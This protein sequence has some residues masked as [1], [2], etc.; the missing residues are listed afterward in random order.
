MVHSPYMHLANTE[1]QHQQHTVIHNRHTQHTVI[2]T[3]IHFLDV[4]LANM[5]RRMASSNMKDASIPAARC[6]Y[7]AA[8]ELIQI[9]P[10]GEAE[11]GSQQHTQ[12]IRAVT[13]F[14]RVMSSWAQME[15][16]LRS[17]S[18]AKLMSLQSQFICHVLHLGHV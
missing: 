17:G 15:F 7:R 10:N 16:D 6:F 18:G 14:I 13:S 4:Q 1:L 9:K 5:E 11:R 2:H 12:L 3:V 8:A